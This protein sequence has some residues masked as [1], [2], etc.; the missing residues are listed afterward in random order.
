MLKVRVAGTDI[1]GMS[2]NATGRTAKKMPAH[3]ALALEAS[4]G[5]VSTQHIDSISARARA[6][7]DAGYPL[8]LAG[9]AGTGKTTLALHLAHMRG[10]PVALIHGNDSFN[11]TDLAGQDRGY[12]RS[13]VIDNYIHSVMKTEESLDLTWVE[14]RLTRAC[15]EGH[16]LV[17]D[18]FNRTRAEANN[19]L[20]GLLEEGL[21]H[22][23]SAAGGYVSVHPEFRIILTS[24]PAEYAGTHKAQDALLDRLITIRCSHYD[25]DTELA[26]VRASSGIDEERARK[27]VGLVRALR[28]ENGE[29]HL[30]SIRSAI[31]LARVTERVGVAASSQEPLFVDMAW[32]MLGS[33]VENIAEGDQPVTRDEF[34]ALMDEVM[35]EV[36]PRRVR[37]KVA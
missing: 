19:I 28:G 6:Y 24:N 12:K 2:K 10:R 31:A 22:A 7:L 37:N 26:I 34:R 35:P 9:P 14:N 23:P 32:D 1:A 21:L 13:A 4:E 33:S 20:L 30:P 17:Y 11:G 27:I 3:G 15:R 5:F 18:E 25:A 29:E 8:H 16:T 36:Q